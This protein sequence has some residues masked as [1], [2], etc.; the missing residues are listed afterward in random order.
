MTETTLAPAEVPDNAAELL[1]AGPVFTK[2]SPEAALQPC[3]GHA[4]GAVMAIVC[5]RLPSGRTVIL[6]GNCA[7]KAGYEHT[8]ETFHE[9]KQKGSDH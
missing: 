8:R 5:L 7:R 6:C 4:S 3:D 9:N 1:T 2:L